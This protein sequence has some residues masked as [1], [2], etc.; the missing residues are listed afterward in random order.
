MTLGIYVVHKETEFSV[1]FEVMG[2]QS[3]GFFLVEVLLGT[4]KRDA[5]ERATHR[6]M[7]GN[8]IL[9]D[10]LRGRRKRPRCMTA[11]KDMTA[12]DE[13]DLM[14]FVRHKDSDGAFTV[15]ETIRFQKLLKKCRPRC[16]KKLAE[17]HAD[18][19]YDRLL[20]AFTRA[21]EVGG[22]VLYSLQPLKKDG[23]LE[24][25]EDEEEEEEEQEEEEEDDEEEEQEE[26]EEEEEEQD[27]EEE[28]EE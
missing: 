9:L 1:A 6:M 17:N 8:T 5:F 20:K 4:T 28:E 23:T 2:F 3:F 15:E 12:D 24:E 22:F 26:E 27:D 7:L 21:V 16:I 14:D 13:T 11:H 19:V 10:V 18:G 25:D